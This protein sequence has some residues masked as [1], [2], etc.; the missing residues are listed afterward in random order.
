M[1]RVSFRDK[2]VL[3][4]G[5]C[6]SL[7]FNG[8]GLNMLRGYFLIN[9][10]GRVQEYACVSDDEGVE[11]KAVKKEVEGSMNTNTQTHTHTQ[12]YTFMYAKYAL[13][14]VPYPW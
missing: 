8:R 3:R 5:L 2:F 12:R 14:R 6:K 11:N 9:S 1:G 13:G 7:F 4:A 10:P